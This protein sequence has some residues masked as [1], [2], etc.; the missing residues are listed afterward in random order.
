MDTLLYKIKQLP[1]SVQDMINMYNVDHR[2]Q[3][4]LVCQQLQWVD[5]N[6]CLNRINNTTSI[7]KTILFNEYCFCSNYC[8][9]HFEYDVRK[10]NRR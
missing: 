7:Y 8:A 9:Y 1:Q 10:Q 5:C 6:E 2:I 4:K 3:M